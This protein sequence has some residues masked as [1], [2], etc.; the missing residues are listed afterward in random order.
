MAGVSK[1]TDTILNVA[2]H[3][4]AT[5]EDNQMA[6]LAIIGWAFNTQKNSLIEVSDGGKFISR[7]RVL[8][9]PQESWGCFITHYFLKT[10]K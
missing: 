1:A 4:G 10:G 9:R 6:R 8:L 2:K 5:E 3:L 7:P